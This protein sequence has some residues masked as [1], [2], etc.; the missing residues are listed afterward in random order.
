MQKW[1]VY[2]VSVLNN[3]ELHIKKCW[4]SGFH[5]TSLKIKR[6][7]LP[8]LHTKMEIRFNKLV[9]E[10]ASRQM[11]DTSKRNHSVSLNLKAR[12]E[13][14]FAH[15]SFSPGNQLLTAF[16]YTSN[17]KAKGRLDGFFL[18]HPDDAPSPCKHFSTLKFYIYSGH[19]FWKG[20]LRRNT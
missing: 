12:A 19:R 6:H 4:T 18:R 10:V 3:K 11:T 2:K 1:V 17:G 16:L 20:R 14:K 15:S 8:R 5:C 9:K 13:L 7:F